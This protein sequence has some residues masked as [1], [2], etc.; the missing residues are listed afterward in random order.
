LYV[1]HNLSDVLALS[2]SVSV[3]QDGHCAGTFDSAAASYDLLVTTMLG[4]AADPS[5]VD[6]S[7]NVAQGK[8]RLPLVGRSSAR[9]LSVRELRAELLKG[10]D[11]DLFAGECVCVMGLSGS[12]REELNYALSGAVPS[13]MRSMEVAGESVSRL[14]PKTCR[15][16]R[17]AL[18]PGN[19][20]AGSLISAFTVRENMSLVSLDKH[21]G[22]LGHVRRKSEASQTQRWMKRFE[23]RPDDQE[24]PTANLSGGNKQKLILAKWMDIDPLVLLI[25]EPTAGVDVTAAAKIYSELRHFADVGGAILITTSES[26]DVLAVA[27]RVL[28]LHRGR[29]SRELTNASEFTEEALLM[30]MN[31]SF[32]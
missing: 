31:Q 16:H 2:S 20:M 11:L 14:D 1:S 17:V 28:I 27:D 26:D 30:A 13:S 18:V 21:R 7:G 25:D 15:E 22:R 9:I 4:D 24:Y 19:R 6:T 23:I 12:G 29:V 8:R 5:E 3:L 10:V 32:A